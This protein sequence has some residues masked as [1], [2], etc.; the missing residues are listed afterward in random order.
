MPKVPY[1]G[2]CPAQ[3]G[4][5]TTVYREYQDTS[6]FQAKSHQEG[7]IDCLYLGLGKCEEEYCPILHQKLR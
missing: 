3:G 5:I 2:K 1:T 7:L 6:G 4:V